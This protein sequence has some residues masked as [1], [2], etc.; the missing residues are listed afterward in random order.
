MKHAAAADDVGLLQP[1]LRRYMAGRCSMLAFGLPPLQVSAPSSHPRPLLQHAALV[2]VM[3]GSIL[4]SVSRHPAVLP[5]RCG[6]SIL[7]RPPQSA[8]LTRLNAGDCLC[9]CD[10]RASPVSLRPAS[11]RQAVVQYKWS[12]V[13][14]KLMSVQLAAYAVWLISFTVFTKLFQARAH[15]ACKQPPRLPSVALT[16]PELHCVQLHVTACHPVTVASGAACDDPTAGA[17]G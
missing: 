1:T 17:R 7:L 5:G 13:F 3:P 11:E 14:V 15:A 6:F 10:R 2:M 8:L 4:S 9:V 16:T 12:N